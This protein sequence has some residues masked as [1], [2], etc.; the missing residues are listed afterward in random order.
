MG[1]AEA[2]MALAP[3]INKD[4]FIVIGEEARGKMI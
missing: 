2:R 3:T 1:L 4:A